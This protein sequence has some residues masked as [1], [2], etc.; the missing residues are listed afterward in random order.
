[1]NP[2][3]SIQ[4]VIFDFDG[5]IADTEP[6]HHQAFCQVAEPDG[7]ACA[8]DE[9]VR[10]YIGYDDRDLFRVAY[11]KSGR[12]LTD[13]DVHARVEAKAQAFIKLTAHGVQTYDGIPD[14]I[15][16]AQELFPVGLCSGALRSDIEPILIQLGLTNVFRVIVTAEDVPMSKPDPACYRLVV[17]RMSSA[18]ARPLATCECVA[19]EDTPG[20]IRAA[21][22]AGLQVWAVTHTHE[23]AAVAQ[24]DEVFDAL[25]EI[26][27]RLEATHEH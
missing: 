1:M 12:A 21:K 9:Y 4:A 3:H 13:A 16:R 17:E 5:V 2:T 6:L 18:I 20:G 24:A 15:V 22:G 7:L 23:P 10:D 11:K 8:W 14:L 27:T 19:I 26:M 25:P